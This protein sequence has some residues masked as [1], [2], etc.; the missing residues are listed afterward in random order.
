M[1]GGTEENYEGS[2]TV[3]WPRFEPDISRIHK[4]KALQ[5][6]RACSVKLLSGILRSL[7]LW[8]ISQIFVVFCKVSYPYHE[9][10][11]HVS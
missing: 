3:P 8:H 7:K 10:Y 11:G 5:L 2:Q 1:P 4:S 6:E 9:F